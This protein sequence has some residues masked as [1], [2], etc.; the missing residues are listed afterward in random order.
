MSSRYDKK[1]K[2]REKDI[3]NTPYALVCVVK[4]KNIDS[5]QTTTNEMSRDFF[6]TSSHGI[7]RTESESVSLH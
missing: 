7:R 5:I 1:A 6:A 3:V 2:I 4:S